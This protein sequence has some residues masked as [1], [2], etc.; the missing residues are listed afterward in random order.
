MT[1]PYPLG[2]KPRAHEL[3]GVG[4]NWDSPPWGGWGGREEAGV[5]KPS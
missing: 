1:P 3:F 2:A 5:K 4:F